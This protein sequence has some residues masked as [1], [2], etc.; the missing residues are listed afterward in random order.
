MTRRL[1]AL[2]RIRQIRERTAAGRIGAAEAAVAAADD[3]AATA[4]RERLR[5]AFPAGSPMDVGSLRAHQLQLLAL[6]DADA[7]AQAELDMAR[8]RRDQQRDEW[9]SAQVHLRS[10]E[11]LVER[12][13]AT[14]AADASARAQAAADEMAVM[15]RGG[16][17]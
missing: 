12:R 5:W 3:A 8:R 16:R 14:A 11:R 7:L 9:R 10:A 15:R 6:H 17:R 1:D 2:L 4:A 13:V